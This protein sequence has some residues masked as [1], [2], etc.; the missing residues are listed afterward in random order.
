MIVSCNPLSAQEKSKQKPSPCASSLVCVRGG[1]GQQGVGEVW[2]QGRL[3]E[4]REQ[5]GWNSS[6]NCVQQC[7]RVSVSVSVSVHVLRALNSMPSFG[8]YYI[9]IECNPG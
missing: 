2:L 7:E 9:R 4:R 3:W 8:S 1:G 6:V 5:F